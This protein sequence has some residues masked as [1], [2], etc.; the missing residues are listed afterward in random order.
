M[1]NLRKKYH[2]NFNLLLDDTTDQQLC[3]LAESTHLSKSQ[4]VR[5]TIRNYHAMRYAQKA[6]CADG[7]ECRCPHTHLYTQPPPAQQQS[8]AQVG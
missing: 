2:I 5:Q 3:E 6:G 8:P 4:L 1:P 7:S